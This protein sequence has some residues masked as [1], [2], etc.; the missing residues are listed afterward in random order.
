M[1]G[2]G[3][4]NVPITGNSAGFKKAM[5][6][7]QSATKRF[8][9]S[10]VNLNR[11][12]KTMGKSMSKMGRTMSMSLT[13]PLLAMGAVAVKSFEDQIAAEKRLEDAVGGAADAL[14]KQASELQKVTRFGDEATMAVQAQLA[15]LGLNEQQIL[16]LTPLIQDLSART[17]KD[18]TKSA[19]EVTSALSTG[20]TTLAKY[21]VEL[22]ATNT[23]S[24]NL[25]ITVAGLTSTIGGQA[26]VL[27]DEG[28]GPLIQMQNA[29][30][31]LMEQFG[32]I[33]ADAIKPFVKWI[34]ELA[35]KF[36]NLSPETK[37]WIVI[38]G[39][40]LAA[41]GPLLMTL[42]F[43]A[44]TVLP[45]LVTAFAALTGPIGLIV[46]AV[47]IAVT[48]I[49]RNW[50]AIVDYFTTG[51]AAAAWL[52]F[53]E[54]TS[55]IFGRGGIEGDMSGI[56][57]RL[58]KIW[59]Y[60]VI[61]LITPIKQA[62]EK[63]MRIFKTAFGIIGDII[64]LFSAVFRSEWGVMFDEIKSIA[65]RALRFI[66][67]SI[68]GSLNLMLGIVG[69]AVSVFNDDW[70]DAIKKAQDSITAMGESVI[71]GA[72]DWMGF[73]EAVSSSKDAL[74]DVS[75]TI[76][77]DV[78]IPKPPPTRT[79][80]GG[81]DGITIKLNEQAEAYKKVRKSIADAVTTARLFGDEEVTVADKMDIV[82]SGI[83]S[84]IIKFGE[85]SKVVQ[86]L[87]MD[88]DALGR[89][90]TEGISLEQF[91]EKISEVI[92]NISMVMDSFSTIATQGFKNQEIAMENRYKREVDLINNSKKSQEQKEKA[93]A[94]LNDSMERKR[95]ALAKKRAKAEKAQALMTAIVNT[96]ASVTKVLANPLMAVLVA[97]L[98]AAQIATI[99]AQPIPE[100]AKGG[101]AFGSTLSVVGDNPNARTDPEVIAPLSKLKDLI[102]FDN[103]NLTSTIS[104][105]D[106]ILVTNRTNANRGFI[107]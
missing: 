99:A 61:A 42:G 26:Q 37:K 88:F 89:S 66:V 40:L 33:I 19:K 51:P 23:L 72:A 87:K 80:G 39:G 36:Q 73:T 84:A 98:G 82:R 57:D 31:D 11:K 30:G 81:G 13:A 85:N 43:L 107:Q 5:A 76:D 53:Q 7:A 91:A 59:D 38:I 6:G 47:G 54:L 75:T 15:T 10:T 77:E 104:G 95:S 65:I 102:S 101:L 44:T 45:G 50:D 41:L 12:L 78:T 14:K 3:G 25:D 20:A 71:K 55:K 90:M 103:I 4:V 27:A 63:I 16:K 18:L 92:D 100:L 1:A 97:A 49:I 58:I 93:L 32:A 79:T 64:D 67:E 22:N 68:S 70:A 52:E 96:A 86:A 62:F 46:L 29:M 83:E 60:L 21:G 24:E 17:G 105:E 94:K 2:V 106:I 8:Q 9:K 48:E 34:K 35:I 28:I 69:K 56:T 74:K